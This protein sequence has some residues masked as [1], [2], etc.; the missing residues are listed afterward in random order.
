MLVSI[1]WI[2]DYVDLD[3][4]DIKGLI[5]KFTLATAEVEDIYY[6]GRD[7][8]KVVV[9]EIKTLENHPNSKK[10]HLLTVDIGDKVVNCV[11]GAPNVR[12]G[13]KVAFATVGGR[14]IAG[15]IGKANIAGYE[16]EGMCCSEKELGISDENSGIMEL[17]PSYKNGTDIKKLFPIDDIVFEVD[18]K[19]L[20]NRPDLWGH[21]GIAREFA[22]LTG[23]ELKPLDLADISSD[24]KETVPVTIGD[25]EHVFRYSCL[26]MANIT[27]HVS[28]MEIRI[29][30]FY[31]GMRPINL[32]ADLTNYIMLEI[33]QP[34][35]AFDATKIDHIKVDTPKEDIDFV[36]LDGTT[37]RAD[38]NTLLIY[39]R[40]EPV[41]IAGIMGG[42]DSEIVGDTSSVVLES[43][44]FDG[45]CVR[46]SS[47]RL[48]LRT[49]AS[50]R[51]EKM[52]DPE[53]TLLAVKRFVKLVKDID[54]GA[55]IDSQ[56]TDEYVRKYP[57]I[58]LTFDKAYVDRYTGIEISNERIVH[59]L[60]LLG[61]GVEEK[62]NVF[63]VTVPS[64]RA[65]KDVTIKADIIEEIT[66]IYGYDNFEI[67]TTRSPL[68]PVHS[69]PER[70]VSDEIKDI[71]VK[72]YSMHE[73]NSYIW[74]DKK[75][76]KK[77]GIEVEDNV[78]ILNIENSDNGVLRNSMLPT[79]LVAAYENKDFSDDYG[80][81]E[82]GRVIDGTL[83]NGY[84][85]ERRHL[86]VVLFSKARSERDLYYKAIETVNC[87]FEQI[88]HCAPKFAKVA[89]EHAWQHP[90]NTAA[91]LADGKEIGTLCALHPQNAAKLD[92]T[93]SAVCI[94]IDIDDFSN[95]KAY[96]IA[97]KEP[98]SRQSTYYDLS[99]V[100]KN[101]VTFDEL[102]ECWKSLSIN[103]LESVKLIDTYE[104]L[105]TKSITLRFTFSSHSR[106][107]EMDEVQSWIN[108]ILRRLAAIGVTLRV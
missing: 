77:L 50:A 89:P 46:K 36:T 6:M 96:D 19:S 38:T 91:I 20:T 83:E 11:C 53:L 85:N 75:K 59:T 74:C 12:I 72:K 18:N 51:Y 100:L 22:A 64:W 61:F 93:G 45:I 92:K 56:L 58:T 14:V 105:G 5:N 3:G 33:G 102:S 103:E 27:K 101:G 104:L 47:S 57:E 99:L 70:L 4:C 69:A 31:C 108:E 43:A 42:L 49:D 63:T 15:E 13:Q 48:G 95:V 97:F 7:V 8:Q 40:D 55:V 25:T 32:L 81:F 23:R 1:N 9:G 2:K 79:L 44:N 65:T 54:D 10:L 88:K 28:P 60:T 98:S 90:K 107:L 86:G 106:T 37:R 67:T 24:S 39:N 26:R 35:H 76:Y 68:K 16:S 17:D 62:D 94:E 84:C 34:T 52:L 87:I 82:I 41:A 29:R 80:I 30:L 78:K 73:V 66:R 71:L 21:Y